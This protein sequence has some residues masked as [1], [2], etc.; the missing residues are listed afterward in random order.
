[1]KVWLIVISGI[2][3]LLES[4][5]SLAHPAAGGQHVS[6]G[7]MHSSGGLDVMIGLALAG[8]IIWKLGSSRRK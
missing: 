8:L 5:L 7:L 2:S 3:L 4:T 1:M 6:S